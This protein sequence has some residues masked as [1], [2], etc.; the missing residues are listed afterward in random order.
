MELT[1]SAVI[2]EKKQRMV[3]PSA[4]V[5]KYCIQAAKSLDFSFPKSNDQGTVQ[6]IY[7][8]SHNLHDLLVIKSL[9][10]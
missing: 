8:C 6:D 3:Y 1:V 2:M 4:E 10:P 9:M 7:M 5:I